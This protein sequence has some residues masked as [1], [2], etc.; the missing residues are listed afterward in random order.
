MSDRAEVINESTVRFTRRF[1]ASQEQVW[2][3]LVNPQ[4]RKLWLC[5]GDWELDPRGRA[6]MIF[7]NQALSDPDDHPPRRYADDRVVHEGQ[8]RSVEPPH[9]LELLWVEHDGSRSEVRVELER[10]QSEVVLRLTHSKLTNQDMLSGVCAG[11][12]A[13]LDRWLAVAH[14]LEPPSFWSRF[15]EL[16]EAVYGHRIDTDPADAG[17][18][19]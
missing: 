2:D 13:H 1:Q 11:W 7:D 3:F 8:L 17:S 12:H 18:P 5:A 6:T 10:E 16:A 9:F 19:N 4:K 15:N 14:G